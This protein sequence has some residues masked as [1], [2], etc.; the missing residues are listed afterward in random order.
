MQTS[1][2]ITGVIVFFGGPCP[3]GPVP[4]VKSI[5]FHPYQG[6]ARLATWVLLVWG[7]VPVCL[8]LFFVCFYVI[9]YEAL[10]MTNFSLGLVF[11]VLKYRLSSKVQFLYTYH[12]K[13]IWDQI[14]SEGSQEIVSQQ[15]YL[16]LSTHIEYF[17]T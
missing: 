4:G 17:Q 14:I 13:Y 6:H 7:F 8:F 12:I 15:Y 10:L 11:D 9:Y 3:L 1:L 2:G 5:S 16:T